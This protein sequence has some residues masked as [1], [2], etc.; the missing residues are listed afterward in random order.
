M[1]THPKEE[2]L[3]PVPNRW[4]RIVSVAPDN[5]IRTPHKAS[6]TA[7]YTE[8]K[9][10]NRTAIVAHSICTAEY[11]EYKPNNRTAIVAHSICITEYTEC[12]RDNPSVTRSIVTIPIE[13]VASAS[14]PLE[15]DFAIG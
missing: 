4:Q 14:A 1:Y 13:T 6:F 7:K 9:P 2:N 5:S 12:K 15:I 11:A 8:C 3:Q 10:N